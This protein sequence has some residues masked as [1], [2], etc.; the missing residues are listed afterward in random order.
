M[1]QE[2]SDIKTILDKSL[3][4]AIGGGLSGAVAMGC[5]VMSLMWL[6]TTI[7]YQYRYGTNTKTAM[8]NLFKEGG[9]R[10]FY[11]GIGPSLFLGPLSRFG[12]TAANAGMFELLNSQ[13]KTKD[14]SVSIKTMSA[15]LV[16]SFAK[17]DTS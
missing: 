6:R 14:L 3:K 9:F 11:R 15:S 16:A 13:D 1:S 10:R 4:R 17:M 8:I 2:N 12:D 7:N 5:Q